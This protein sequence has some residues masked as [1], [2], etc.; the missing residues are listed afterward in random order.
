MEKVGLKVVYV[1]EKGGFET[2]PEVEVKKEDERVSKRGRGELMGS[3]DWGPFAWWRTPSDF[4]T[5]PVSMMRRFRDEMDRIFSHIFKEEFNRKEATWSPAI[6]VTE[7]HGN[8][9]VRAELPGLKPEDVK[10]E[11][12]D[13]VLMIEGERK[14]EHE[15][16][17]KGVFRSERRYGKFYREIPL[18]GGASVD[19]AKAQFNNGVLE[20]TLRVPEHMSKRKEIPITTG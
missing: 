10:I 11:V 13:E 4:F 5:N 17:G 8:L 15:E 20:V 7:E 16:K 2:M 14:Y 18:P 3:G 9:H 6:E 12:T 1:I 19:K